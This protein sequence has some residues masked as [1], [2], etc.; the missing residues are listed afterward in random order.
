MWYFFWGFL[1]IFRDFSLTLPTGGSVNLMPSFLG[2][3]LLLLGARQTESENEH[4]HRILLASV[5]ALLISAAQF[6]FA[7]FAFS[8]VELVLFILSTAAALYITYEFTEGAKK[9]ERSRYKKFGTDKLS[10]AWILLC[11]TALL[12]FLVPFMPTISLTQM[13]VHLLALTWFETSVYS[14]IRA[15]QGR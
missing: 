10:T 15:L 13:L 7:I 1:F 4:F 8:A 11:M 6:V 9:I 14:F 2:F 3:A 12:G 5:A